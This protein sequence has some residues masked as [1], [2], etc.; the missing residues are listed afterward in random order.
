M[1]L[2]LY[3][4]DLK[5]KHRGCHADKATFDMFTDEAQAAIRFIGEATYNAT[6]QDGT[7]TI[8]PPES[9]RDPGNPAEGRMTTVGEHDDVP[10]DGTMFR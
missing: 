7:C 4:P 6:W 5:P 3:D 9:A 1:R 10:K 8:R 2:T